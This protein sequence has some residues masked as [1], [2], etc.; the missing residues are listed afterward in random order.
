MLINIWNELSQYSIPEII[1][2]IASLSYTLLAAR[3]NRACW[4]A[5]FIGSL[6]YIVVFWQ[7]KLY[8]DSALNIYYAAMAVVG[9]FSWQASRTLSTAPMP[10]LTIS[11]PIIPS[12]I[13]QW[14]A[15]QHIQWISLVL[16]LSAISGYFLAKLTDAAFP[17]LDS[18]TTWASL[19]A[20]WMVVK[21][22]LETW[23]YWL[24]IDFVSMLLYFNKGLLF[25]AL[26]FALYVVIV[27][28]AYFNWRK[29]MQQDLAT[30]TH[31]NLA[32]G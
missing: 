18:F 17:Y 16:I 11:S 19:L 1:A 10:P 9:W 31:L 20:T 26:L 30:S 27:I 3:E 24:V 8:M 32:N 25:T 5:A 4:P 14:Q 7:Y 13:I 21:K 29:I 23:L 15:K 22:V 12:P 2:V 6:I 28:Y